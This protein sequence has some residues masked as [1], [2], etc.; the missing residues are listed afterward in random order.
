M[1]SFFKGNWDEDLYLYRLTPH[2]WSDNLVMIT[3]Q[4]P[5]WQWR[6]FVTLKTNSNPK[7]HRRL[8]LRSAYIWQHK[9]TFAE[10]S[11]GSLHILGHILNTSDKTVHK[12]L[13]PS[14]LST[15]KSILASISQRAMHSGVRGNQSSGY[16][17][18]TFSIVSLLVPVSS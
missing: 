3:T 13:C 2:P 5:R 12:N 6:G 9:A 18:C 1:C 7:H 15:L 14:S 17:W 8:V 11:I 16:S 4:V 10:E